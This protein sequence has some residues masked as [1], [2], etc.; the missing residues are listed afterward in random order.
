MILHR[1]KIVFLFF[2]GLLSLAFC[3]LNS[4]KKNQPGKSQSEF[5]T[6]FF[7]TSGVNNAYDVKQ[8]LDGGYIVLGSIS[9]PGKGLDIALVK[10]DKFGN[11]TWTKLFGDS[12]NDEGKSF[13][14]NTDGT[15]VITGY[16]TTKNASVIHKDVCVIKTDASGNLL[17]LS[18]KII[19]TTNHEEGNCIR[20]TPDNCYIITGYTTAANT[21]N[22]NLPGKMDI[23]I[24][25]INSE[26]NVLWE[27]SRGG[28]EN[29]IGNSI[30]AKPDGGYIVIGTTESF[31]ET[32]KE[33]LNII[34]IE[35]NNLGFQNDMKIYGGSENDFGES[36][37]PTSDGGYVF[38]GTTG[39]ESG[40]SE[41]YIVKLKPGSIRNTEWE[42]KTENAVSTECKSVFPAK[43][44]TFFATGTTGKN[45]NKDIFLMKINS[46]GASNFIRYFGEKQLDETANC[47]FQTMDEGCIL[48]GQNAYKMMGLIKTNKNGEQ[49]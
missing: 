29:D 36:I 24:L 15:I 40:A 1:V 7:G 17:W 34:L 14:I 30:I 9:V 26:G 32:G 31:I 43:D 20:I 4:C 16:Y 39:A 25:K 48:A 2:V 12:L 27:N 35:T 22:Q 18:P 23:L 49:K 28:P 11:E 41:A 38:C 6:K 8:T 5:F 37:Q 42:V 45:T 46:D 19:G 13:I 33:K 3:I 44:N 21:A 10:T 47:V